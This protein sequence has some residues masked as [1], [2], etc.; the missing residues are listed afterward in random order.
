MK[1]KSKR[2]QIEAMIAERGLR[3]EPFGAAGAVRI[4]GPKVDLLVAPEHIGRLSRLDL[5]SAE[6]RALQ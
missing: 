2:E 3:I 1:Q 6:D 4:F 5:V